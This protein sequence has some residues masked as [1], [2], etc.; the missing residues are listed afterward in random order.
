M[1]SSDSSS[2][3]EISSTTVCDILTPGRAWAISITQRNTV[4]EEI[5]RAFIGSGAGLN[6]NLIYR[7]VSL[8]LNHSFVLLFWFTSLGHLSDF[9]FLNVDKATLN[10]LFF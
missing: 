8:I 4:N 5:S 10:M 6:D 7:F 1:A 3:G 2:V 9:L